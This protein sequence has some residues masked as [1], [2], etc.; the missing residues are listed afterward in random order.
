[1]GGFSFRSQFGCCRCRTFVG[2]LCA[3]KNPLSF[4]LFQHPCTSIVQY[5]VSVGIINYGFLLLFISCYF[6]VPSICYVCAC[7]CECVRCCYFLFV[8]FVDKQNDSRKKQQ[9]PAK[10]IR[11]YFIVCLF[12]VVVFRANQFQLHQILFLFSEQ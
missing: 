3:R 8:N 2:I 7:E 12:E 6:L 9:Q 1:M 11:F 4:S 10:S 5:G